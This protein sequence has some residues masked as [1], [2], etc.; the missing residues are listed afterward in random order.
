MLLDR[1][2]AKDYVFQF[3]IGRLKTWLEVEI[4]E[5]RG[6]FQFLIGRLKTGPRFRHK[7]YRSQFQFLIG[8]L[9]TPDNYIGLAE[10]Y[11]FNSL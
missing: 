3:L 1:I 11:S 7:R 6:R 8:R 2:M 5:Y 10:E 9:K 4:G